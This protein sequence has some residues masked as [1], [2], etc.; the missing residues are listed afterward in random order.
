MPTP[1]ASASDALLGPVR[2]FLRAPTQEGC[3]LVLEAE[4]VD[5]VLQVVG[6]SPPGL[7]ASCKACGHRV[8]FERGRV[9][10]ER[11]CTLC[12]ATL[13]P[14][15]QAGPH[16]KFNVF[17]WRV[18][19]TKEG[20]EGLGYGASVDEGVFTDAEVLL[21]VA[22]MHSVLRLYLP[23]FDSM[24]V[25]SMKDYRSLV[26]LRK[27]GGTEASVQVRSRDGASTA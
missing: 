23:L 1:I 13:G 24:N 7:A 22:Q 26:A 25:T 18:S 4:G 6:E 27:D 19:W 14:L 2:D 20:F 15:E 17:A 10:Q 5:L 16:E 12:R 3:F 9:D 11:A 21:G 8:R